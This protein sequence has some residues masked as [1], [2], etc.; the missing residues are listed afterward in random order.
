MWGTIKKIS[1]DLQE[2][3]Q[4]D[5]GTDG[6]EDDIDPVPVTT[7]PDEEG[8]ALGIPS[9]SWC[10]PKMETGLGDMTTIPEEEVASV[11]DSVTFGLPSQEKN[12]GVVA[13]V[14]VECQRGR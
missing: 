12:L 3:V 9:S 13:S 5:V 14:L 2:L 7:H 10:P 6:E 1:N 8:L 4:R 11:K